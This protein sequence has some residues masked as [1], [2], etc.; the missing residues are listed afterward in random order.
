MNAR[1]TSP[2]SRGA[3]FGIV[4]VGFLA[5]FAMLYFMSVGDTGRTDDNGDAHAASNGLA[6]YSALARLLDAEGYDVT[7]SREE[8]GLDSDGLLVMTPPAFSDAE[9]LS[10][11]LRRR[12]YIGPT[13][14]IVPKWMTLGFP[15]NLPAEE[16]EKIKQGWVQ[17]GGAGVPDWLEELDKP[18]ALEAT[19]TASKPGQTSAAAKWT[20]FQAS[21]K[22]PEAT[23]AGLSRADGKQV[24]V[25][26]NA[27]RALAVTFANQD[28]FGDSDETEAVTF[29]VEPDLVNNYGMSDA[30]RAALAL[31]LINAAGYGEDTPITFDLTLNGLGGTVNLLTLAF[32]PPFLA[33][34][35]CLLLAMLIVGWRAFKRF[36][37]TLANGP[38]IAFGKSR[39]VA[40]GAGL[41]VRARRLR[42]LAEPYADLSARRLATAL[43][44]ARHDPEA[45]DAALKRRLPDEEPFSHRANR[46]RQATSS[47]EILRAAQALKEL[48]G[49]LSK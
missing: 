34:T 27:D 24:L 20:D 29:I 44:L 45:I 25:H 14:V 12:A 46:L 19:L 32:R 35:L 39:L 7:L 9:E 18:Y 30:Q 11:I 1:R 40:N 4:M 36:G 26:D 10:R 47:T 49:K 43:G 22:L 38:D 21:G 33:A 8:G 3:V 15:P 6:G 23:I 41:I 28:E 42:L 16:A 37:P 48:E 31:R 13:L 17:L 2:F 5:F